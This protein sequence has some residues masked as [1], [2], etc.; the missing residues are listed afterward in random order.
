[1]FSS[2]I[3]M[4]SSVPFSARGC[5]PAYAWK[6]TPPAKD[7]APD[8][9]PEAVCLYSAGLFSKRIGTAGRIFMFIITSF[10]MEVNILFEENQ[11]FITYATQKL[12]MR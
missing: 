7:P 8:R 3:K 2:K 10:Q 12:N 11:K 1:M 6:R 9:S 5:A 4:F